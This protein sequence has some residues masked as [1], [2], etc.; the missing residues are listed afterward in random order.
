MGKAILMIIDGLGYSYC[1]RLLGNVEGWVARGDARVWKGQSVLP[2]TSGP[3][4]ASIH[5]GLDPQDHGVLTNGHTGRV[6]QPDIF[7][8]ARKAGLRTGAIAH[9]Y[10]SDYFQRSPFDPL[11]DLEV[12]DENAPIQHAR[13]YT[14]AGEG[15]GNLAIPSDYDL[16]ALMT[17]MIKRKAPDYILFHSSTTDSIGHAYGA[18]SIQMDQ[19]AYTIDGAISTYLPHWLEQGYEV[20]ITADHGQSG[21]GHHGGTEDLMR[22]IAIYYF[23]QAEG[24]QQDAVISQRALAPTILSRLGV[25]V[26]DS[27]KEQ[28]FLV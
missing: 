28:P 27:M 3:C 14:M 19:T 9:S 2:S 22:D 20:F 11:E 21:R 7:S 4:Y 5:T 6:A 26:P 24:P 16:M 1:R 10:F 18:D 17:M 12:D 8:E 23:G 13:F 15:G 25:P